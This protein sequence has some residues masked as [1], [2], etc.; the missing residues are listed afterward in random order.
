MKLYKL[1]GFGLALLVRKFG[2]AV[3]AAKFGYGSEGRFGLAT[4]E[5]GPQ[6]KVER[7]VKVLIEHL[8]IFLL[9][10]SKK[11][12]PVS[13]KFHLLET[14]PQKQKA[15]KQ[16]DVSFFW[17]LFPACTFWIIC[18]LLLLFTFCQVC[19]LVKETAEFETGMAEKSNW[20]QAN[21]Q[22]KIGLVWRNRKK[23]SQII[24]D[25][26]Y[27]P[28]FLLI[29][30]W[31]GQMACQHT[32]TRKSGSSIPTLTFRIPLGEG[33][34]EEGGGAGGGGGEGTLESHIRKINTNLHPSQNV[35]QIED[36][37]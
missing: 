14:S 35:G 12:L 21:I 15:Q 2:L 19:L 4:W 10:S 22:Q 25:Y 13:F 20:D 29:I 28:F 11:F 31:T 27:L 1:Q 3:Q 34:S 37:Y 24:K 26:F 16:L 32:H 17:C 5:T 6:R 18:N 23:I 33:P 36:A 9:F 7:Q 8:A 30:L